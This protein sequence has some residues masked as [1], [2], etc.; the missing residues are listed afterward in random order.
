[1]G[2]VTWGGGVSAGD[3]DGAER[4]QF[5]PYDGPPVP[6]G[7]YAFQI[8]RIRKGESSKGNPQ[9]IVGLELVPRQSRPDDKPYKSFYLTDFIPV[10]GSTVERL[11]PFLDAI[12]VTG[13]DLLQRTTD[14]GS[15]DKNILRIGKVTPL[16]KYVLAQIEDNTYE[17]K[18]RKV[19]SFGGY[20]PP[21]GAGG[22]ASEP[23]P[24]DDDADTGDDPPF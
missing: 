22:T 13:A 4:R 19:V 10:M 8:K 9:L 11:A 23:E 21:P 18:T 20:Y 1:M 7:L 15:E 24:S 3:I 2:K 5:K 6:D 12:G 14:D 17:G 16:G